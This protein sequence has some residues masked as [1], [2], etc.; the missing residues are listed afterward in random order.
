MSE[1]LLEDLKEARAIAL[2]SK[3][4]HERVIVSFVT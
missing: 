3:A 4:N 1:Y 2:K